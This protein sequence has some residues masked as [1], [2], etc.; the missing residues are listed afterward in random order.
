MVQSTTTLFLLLVSLLAVTD[1]AQAVA[2]GYGRRGGRLPSRRLGPVGRNVTGEVTE[3]KFM[4][5]E[6]I[7]ARGYDGTSGDPW[8]GFTQFSWAPWT[9][10]GFFDHSLE[11]T[12]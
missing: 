8:S 1:S 11:Y 9:G 7:V 10:Y 6:G 2:V 5:N 12:M 4:E 3:S